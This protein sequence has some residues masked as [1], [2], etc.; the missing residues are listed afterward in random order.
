MA[1][2][3][4]LNLIVGTA[5][6]VDHG[7]SSLV[8]ALTGT[9]PD[10]LPEEQR[11]EIT[12]RLGFAFLKT[13]RGE[14]GIV[15]VPGHEKL[16]REMVAGATGFDA[17]LLVIAAD[18]G[19]MPQTRE[20]LDILGLL[21]INRGLVALTKVD[22]VEDEE[23]LALVEDDVKK[24][25]AKT[26]FANAPILHTSTKTGAGIDE[27]RD[28]LFELAA[29]T[30]RETLVGRPFRLWADRSFTV[31][32]FGSVATGT[33]QGGGISVGD[34]VELFPGRGKARVRGLQTNGRSRDTVSI[35]QRVA[36]NLSGLPKRG[37]KHGN[38]IATPNSLVESQRFDARLRLLASA[39]KPLARITHLKLHLGTREE[40]CRVM[41]LGCEQLMPGEEAFAQIE[42]ER[43]LSTC[44][45]DN[46]LLRYPSPSVTV[47]G[48]RVLDPLAQHHRR[49]RKKSYLKALDELNATDAEGSLTLWLKHNPLPGKE[50]TTT[51]LA[52]RS[53]L[54][55]EVVIP[56][57]QAEVEAG[58][59]AHLGGERWLHSRWHN[60]EIE[61][62]RQGLA[63]LLEKKLPFHRLNRG[64]LAQL[65]G[66]KTPGA[67][68]LTALK[69]LTA[70]GVISKAGADYAVL[71]QGELNDKQR[72]QVESARRLLAEEDPLG[73]H[74]LT[75]AAGLHRDTAVGIARYLDGIGEAAFLED[76]WL[77]GRELYESFRQ[78]AL[79]L[80]KRDGGVRVAEFKEA[81]KLS[82]KFATQLLDHFYDRGMTDRRKGTHVLLDSAKAS[83]SHD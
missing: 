61:K 56:T 82:R 45:N 78:Q 18:E 12:I 30:R 80:I 60:A 23:W 52:R 77:W 37:L 53:G 76:A 46:F 14:L 43:P 58:E 68:L 22:L 54:L 40:P 7:K 19:I 81:T 41:L 72:S 79:T 2:E 36:I 27:L 73:L 38:L 42:P 5:G 69:Q 66:G 9:N 1:D 32:G 4:A 11:R 3:E 50:L 71:P 8:Q 51:E 59:V 20:H 35:G 70:E 17:V 67:A 49:S 29:N 55:A 13:P 74:K 65:S 15:D 28:S 63:K 47:A 26:P 64:E 24:A 10:R 62:L 39:A 33:V 44:F 6:H 48:G 57:L 31:K 83:L 16:V 25:L 75:E 34:S 21:G